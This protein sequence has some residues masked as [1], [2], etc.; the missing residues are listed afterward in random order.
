ME[1]K[2]KKDYY[3]YIIKTNI[4]NNIKEI[5]N[6]YNLSIPKLYIIEATK[7]K[8]NELPKYNSIKNS[9][10]RV[11][12]KSIHNDVDSLEDLDFESPYTKTKK[13]GKF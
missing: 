11:V 10:Y 6:I 9:F 5:G 4:K 1:I 7:I 12:N 2:S 13:N 8:A 3:K